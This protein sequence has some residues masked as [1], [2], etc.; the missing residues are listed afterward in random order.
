M[1]FQAPFFTENTVTTVNGT[2][3]NQEC[4]QEIKPSREGEDSIKPSQEG[5]VEGKPKENNQLALAFANR[6]AALFHRRK[7]QIALQV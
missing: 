6:S 4:S 7:Y 3:Q 1:Y 2:D 5:V